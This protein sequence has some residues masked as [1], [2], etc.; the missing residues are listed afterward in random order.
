MNPPS[1]APRSD[2]SFAAPRVP[3]NAA[4]AFG[5]I[6]RLTAQRFFTRGHWLAVGG[7][8][9]VLGLFA[10]G[11]SASKGGVQHYASWCAGFHVCFLVP[12]L[13][14]ISAA[15]V[16]RDDLK[17]GTVDYVFTRPIRRHLFVAFRYLAHVGCAQLDFLLALGVVIGVGIYRG[18]PAIGTAVPLLL[19][20]QVAVIVVFSAFGFLCAMLTSRYVIVGLVYGG[21]IEVGIGNV[22]TQMNRLSMI[23][24][25][26][27]LLEPVFRLG[28]I[29]AAAMERAPQPGI[30]ATLGMLLLVAAVMLAATAAVFSLKELSGGAGRDG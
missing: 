14:F 18:A 11:A 13:A 7:M 30:A 28:D 24:H 21:I 15:G 29:P 8:L 5:G 22:P 19:L 27:D 25:V 4:H 3:A 1:P 17:A 26:R 16:V 6:W 12:L 10:W 2:L 23:R 20:A 9:V